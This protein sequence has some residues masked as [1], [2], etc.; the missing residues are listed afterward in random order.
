MSLLPPRPVDFADWR[1]DTRLL[2]FSPPIFAS[3]FNRMMSAPVSHLKLPHFR[4]SFH[5]RISKG[6]TNFDEFC[7]CVDSMNKPT[8]V[9]RREM[10]GAWAQ[11]LMR[12]W[13]LWVTEESRIQ[14]LTFLAGESSLDI[15]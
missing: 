9:G 14:N 2:S 7:H 3:G 13:K 12:A 6:N 8:V 4:G 11:Y 15:L 1:R 5:N 10:E